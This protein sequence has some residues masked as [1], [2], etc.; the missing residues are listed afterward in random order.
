M[1][2]H[3][4]II[5]RVAD[6]D[7]DRRIALGAVRRGSTD[8]AKAVRNSRAM[9]GFAAQAGAPT[10]EIADAAGMSVEEIEA[11]VGN[12]G[13]DPEARVRQR[14]DTVTAAARERRDVDD[15]LDAAVRAAMAEGADDDAVRRALEPPGDSHAL[16]VDLDP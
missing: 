5:R 9:I 3:D 11:I 6:P 12:R 2:N 16:R 14:L 8:I 10:A 13:G 1:S 15:W 7:H 4:R